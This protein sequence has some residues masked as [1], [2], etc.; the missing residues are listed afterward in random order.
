MAAPTAGLIVLFG[1]S[2]D[3]VHRG[4]LGIARALQQ[5]VNSTQVVWLPNS[6]SPLK[7]STGANA[8]ARQAMLEVLMG[9]AHE[10]TWSLDLSEL[11]TPTPSFTIDTLKRWRRAIG[12]TQALA[13]LI[14][15]DSLNTLEHWRDWQQLTD[16]A[17]LIVA[18][19]PGNAEKVSDNVKSW[20]ENRQI[21]APEL[22]QSRPFGAVLKLDTPPWP[23][24]SS[25]L[26]TALAQQPVQP[27]QVLDW[28]EPKVWDYIQLHGLY[29]H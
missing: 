16:F 5:H 23:I 17:H 19:R 9:S 12:P 25:E 24:S 6:C 28:L 22:L 26:R 2:F 10:P 21:H 11:Q 13:F 18:H 27:L 4:H 20:L 8:S 7:V 15:E 3:P 29:R 1:G 14:G